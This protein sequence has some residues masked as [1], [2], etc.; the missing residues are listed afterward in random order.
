MFL[1]IGKAEYF[2]PEGWT[3]FFADLPGGENS[4]V[5]WIEHLAQPITS[6]EVDGYRWR[7]AQS[8]ELRRA[9]RPEIR[10]KMAAGRIV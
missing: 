6:K 9:C 1:G 8:Y 7:S 3:R 5:G 4:I 2:S 10:S